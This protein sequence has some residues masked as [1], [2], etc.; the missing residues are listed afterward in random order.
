M[1][2]ILAIINSIT[3][4]YEREGFRIRK[5]EYYAEDNCL[6][7]VANAIDESGM[8]TQKVELDKFLKKGE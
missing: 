4:R 6:Y 8:I 3:D 7:I 5:I 1:T 2:K